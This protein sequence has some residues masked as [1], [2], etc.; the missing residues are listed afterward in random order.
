M[1]LDK[2]NLGPEIVAGVRWHHEP[3]KADEYKDLIHLIHLANMLALSEGIGTG[4]YGM[5]YSCFSE[6]HQVFLA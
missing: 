3:D 1:I 4:I 2:W 5:Q 6:N